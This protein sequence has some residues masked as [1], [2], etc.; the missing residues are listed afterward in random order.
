MGQV[1]RKADSYELK[2]LEDILRLEA[3]LK[4]AED[5]QITKHDAFTE[6]F[7]ESAQN[8]LFDNIQ[9]HSLSGKELST[10]EWM[11]TVEQLKLEEE[12]DEAI[13]MAAA[14]GELSVDRGDVFGEFIGAGLGFQA[15]VKSNDEEGAWKKFWQSLCLILKIVEADTG[16][17]AAPLVQRL[18]SGSVDEFYELLVSDKCFWKCTLCLQAGIAIDAI[19]SKN[20]EGNCSSCFQG[21]G[22]AA[23]ATSSDQVCF[24]EAHQILYRVFRFVQ[25]RYKST[26]IGDLLGDQSFQ[27]LLLHDNMLFHAMEIQEAA[28]CLKQEWK[29]FGASDY[30]KAI[31]R[32][33]T[34]AREMNSIPEK[35][36]KCHGSNVNEESFAAWQLE[37]EIKVSGF[38]GLY[39][40]DNKDYTVAEAN[41]FKCISLTLEHYKELDID[42]GIENVANLFGDAYFNSLKKLRKFDPAFAKTFDHQ[43]SAVEAQFPFKYLLGYQFGKWLFEAGNEGKDNRIKDRSLELLW[44]SSRGLVQVCED[45]EYAI[46]AYGDSVGVAMIL[47][48]D[49]FD[50]PWEIVEEA[51][52]ISEVRDDKDFRLWK[53]L[54]DVAKNSRQPIR[55]GDSTCKIQRAMRGLEKAQSLAMQVAVE[56][57]YSRIYFHSRI[58]FLMAELLIDYSK[59]SGLANAQEQVEKAIEHLKRACGELEERQKLDGEAFDIEAL[60]LLEEARNAL[61]DAY[62]LVGEH[63]QAAETLLHIFPASHRNVMLKSAEAT[64]L[65]SSGFHDEA[66]QAINE[67]ILEAESSPDWKVQVTLLFKRSSIH[68][69]TGQ[70]EK[71]LKDMEDAKERCKAKDFAFGDNME[72][73]EGFLSLL[74]YY[75]DSKGYESAW[76][77]VQG[78]DFTASSDFGGGPSVEFL[79]KYAKWEHLKSKL[80]LQTQHDGKYTSGYWNKTSS[81]TSGPGLVFTP[82]L[83]DAMCNTDVPLATRHAIIDEGKFASIGRGGRP[84]ED[85]PTLHSVTRKSVFQCYKYLADGDGP[86]AILELQKAIEDLESL[87]SRSRQTHTTVYTHLDIVHLYAL[88]ATVYGALGL[89]D[90]A[91]T[92]IE[93]SRVLMEKTQ[94]ESCDPVYLNAKF[95]V[96]FYG[97]ASPQ[98]SAEAGRQLI[99]RFI[100]AQLQMP[101]TLEFGWVQILDEK[102]F[103]YRKMELIAVGQN[104]PSEAL[105]WAERGQMRLFMHIVENDKQHLGATDQKSTSIPVESKAEGKFDR[106]DGY[107]TEILSKAMESCPPDVTVVKYS[108]FDQ[109]DSLVV[110]LRTK[111]EWSMR[112]ISDMG[113][114]FFRLLTVNCSAAEHDP[115][116][117]SPLRFKQ[118]I[119]TLLQKIKKKDDATA[120]QYLGILYQLIISPEL[121]RLPED[122][123]HKLVFAHHGF[124]SGVPLHALFDDSKKEFLI[125]QKRVCY[126]PSIRV[127]RYCFNRQ[128]EFLQSFDKGELKPPF[129][130]GDPKPM[131]RKGKKQLPGARKEAQEVAKVLLGD[132]SHAFVG[133]KVTKQA[134]KEALCSRWL[135]LVSTHC[136]GNALI[137]QRRGQQGPG[138]PT[139]ETQ[140]HQSLD[141]VVAT[142]SSSDNT[143]VAVH[144]DTGSGVEEEELIRGARMPME[145]EF[146]EEE[147]TVAEIVQL[148]VRSGVVV[149]DGCG[150][151]EGQVSQEGLL[152]LGRALLLAGAPMAI[153]TLW[154][155]NDKTTN[156]LVTSEF[157]LLL[158]PLSLLALSFV[159]YPCC[160]FSTRIGKI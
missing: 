89:I 144:D 154:P 140:V 20:G 47:N 104:K 48:G 18:V 77:L 57:D 108:Y 12:F 2:T 4:E 82:F 151:N 123:C 121:Q 51:L 133:E 60:E 119:T 17:L 19:F 103:L 122:A 149:F 116:H 70:M 66:V 120:K 135:T 101:S 21:L 97:N 160:H 157:H 46:Q 99:S 61:K 113:R 132:E 53:I 124:L 8:E 37:L 159:K 134:V 6:S 58:L 14:N 152:G 78:I 71:R 109:D 147:L 68:Q 65:S 13:K 128:D 16:Q 41:L 35:E 107:A 29:Q 150:T 54:W 102:A 80:M 84:S 33:R 90:Q 75:I 114:E 88:K 112:Q 115:K 39:H 110:Y 117:Q 92:S 139:Q 23:E 100:D 76:E 74:E 44:E 5:I 145:G 34:W 127:L 153:L 96:D 94:E 118:Y 42:S 129:L 98:L 125:Q 69:K 28:L 63:R 136:V 85:V 27:L 131:G 15:C 86:R 138:N 142:R 1:L 31:E 43:L 62:G 45:I 40:Y 158:R 146:D 155:V 49:N 25:Q 9:R 32:L 156:S 26:R 36:M 22:V 38:L 59:S 87:P 72:I 141:H 83:V 55:N 73:F 126:I 50:K 106:N 3:K 130:A 91:N 64:S 93:Q 24:E 148:R 10:G 11:A 7:V 137:M 52:N 143:W 79:D 95:F 81:G 111:E 67:A 56:E 105:V 30:V